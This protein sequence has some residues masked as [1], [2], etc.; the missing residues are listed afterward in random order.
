MCVLLGFLQK[1]WAI[2]I[3]N[4]LSWFM[5]YV[6]SFSIE[7]KDFII[8]LVSLMIRKVPQLKAPNV[9]PHHNTIAAMTSQT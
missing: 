6:T 1:P 8:I 4:P 7:H 5:I 9:K 3:M 2:P